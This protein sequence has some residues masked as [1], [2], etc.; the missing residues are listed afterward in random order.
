ML[1][2]RLPQGL[3]SRSWHVLGLRVVTQAGSEDSMPL[4]WPLLEGTAYSIKPR[5]WHQS[6]SVTN[7]KFSF[8]ATQQ[9]F[10]FKNTWSM[11]KDSTRY[12]IPNFVVIERRVSEK[13]EVSDNG[14]LG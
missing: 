5:P 2:Y 9:Y 4:S 6:A 10:Y 13:F 14:V 8:F 3:P 12:C 1:L 7:S 11:L